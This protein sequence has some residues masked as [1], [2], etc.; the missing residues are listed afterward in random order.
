MKIILFTILYLAMQTSVFSQ[1]INLEVSGN[2]EIEP[3]YDFWVAKALIL[4]TRVLIAKKDLFQAEYT[5]KSVIDNYSEQEDGII[6]QANQLWDELM[7]VKNKPKD[8][9]D[10]GTTVI[11]IEEGKL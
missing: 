5:L 3:A 6:M 2:R 7:Q 4:Q 10:P 1:E 9:K 8:V 11:E